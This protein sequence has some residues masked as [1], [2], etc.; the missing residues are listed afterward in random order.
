MEKNPK[1]NKRRASKKAVGPGKKCKIDKCR[2]Y[3]YP[4]L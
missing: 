2:A 1:S 4:G 3:V